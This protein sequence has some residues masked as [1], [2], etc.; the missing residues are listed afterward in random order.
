MR[1]ASSRRFV[2]KFST[3]STILAPK[4]SNGTFLI[5][6]MAKRKSTSAQETADPP[7]RRSLRHSIN[8]AAETE[9]QQVEQKPATNTQPKASSTRGKR[10]SAVITT[11]EEN[12]VNDEVEDKKPEP[13][14]RR[15]GRRSTA[16]EEAVEVNI[17]FRNMHDT[18]LIHANISKELMNFTSL[19]CSFLPSLILTQSRVNILMII[20]APLF[21]TLW[22]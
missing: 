5:T 17:G 18:H 2:N 7:R 19:Y 13:P 3:L 11:E 22:F 1:S 15:G 6:I 4:L 21:L 12:D 16:A 20:S 9:I 8:T 10:K 14:R